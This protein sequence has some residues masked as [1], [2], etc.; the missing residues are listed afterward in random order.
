MQK[1]YKLNVDE[2]LNAALPKMQEAIDTVASNF[3][4]TS[5]PTK[6]LFVGMEC[7]RTDEKKIYRLTSDNPATWQLIWDLSLEAGQA[8]KDGNG[9]NIANTYATKTSLQ[10]LD[11]SALKKD[12][13]YVK[14]MEVKNGKATVTKG[15]GSSDEFDTALN[16][17]QRDKAYEVGDIA[18]SPGLKSYQYVECTTAGTTGDSEP[19]LS[20]TFTDG[21]AYFAIKDMRR[22]N[23][24]VNINGVPFDGTSDILIAT[25]PHHYSRENLWTPGKRSVTIPAYLTLNINDALYQTKEDITLNLDSKG[26]WDSSSSTY[27][28]VG[29][30]KGKDFY[31]Y[32]CTPSSGTVP[33]FILSANSTIPSGK[34]GINSRKIGGFHCECADVGTIKNNDLSGWL[35]GEILPCSAWDLLH[36]SKGENE[37]MV[38]SK[39]DD[40]WLSIYLL[41]NVDGMP[42][43]VFGGVILDGS[44]NPAYHGLKF[45]EQLAKLNMRLPYLHEMF[46]AFKGVSEN[47]AIKGAADPNTTGG[48]VHS[49]GVRIVSNIGLEDCTG[50]LWQW[51][52]NYWASG[53]GWDSSNFDSTVDGGSGYGRTYGSLMLPLGG[54]DWPDGSACGSRA[55]AGNVSAAYRLAIYGARAAGEP[56][57]VNL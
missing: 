14:D 33:E 39:Y 50:V 45:T 31:I 55:V 49:N 8:V 13:E 24:D 48:H 43:S 23:H 32:A 29:N 26:S 34:T 25:T 37:G 22:L 27:A 15:D 54:G 52:N 30:R 42:A 17:L 12:G 4:G 9:N 7:Y 36:R 21:T 20:E 2:Y 16:I 51:S 3:S 57:S 40:V 19:E 11:N 53:S 47:I 35:A 10:S 5:F 6:N 1:Y 56:R 18:Y 46:N 28:T 38:Y 44:S 41:S